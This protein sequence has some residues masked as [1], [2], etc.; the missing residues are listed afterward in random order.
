M[1]LRGDS[2]YSGI[3]HSYHG[4]VSI[5]ILVPVRVKLGELLVKRKNRIFGDEEAGCQDRVL[6]K[7]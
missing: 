6:L 1:Y 7:K 2:H 3:I 5:T 4:Y